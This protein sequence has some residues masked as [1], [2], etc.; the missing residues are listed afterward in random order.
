[1]FADLVRNGFKAPLR[2]HRILWG[3][4][5]ASQS[6]AP[7]PA[8]DQ[9]RGFPVSKGSEMIAEKWTLRGCNLNGFGLSPLRL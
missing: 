9:P 4:T 6:T 1:M 3:Q 7:G 8:Q 2:T 5:I